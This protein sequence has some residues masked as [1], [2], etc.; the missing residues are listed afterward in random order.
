M[1]PE[2]DTLVTLTTGITLLTCVLAVVGLHSYAA[3]KA[4]RAPWSTASPRPARYR[5]PG[6]DAASRP[7]TAACAAPNSAG[8][9]NGACRPPAWT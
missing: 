2:L 3:G 1:E 8:T 7:W 9:W 4:Q 5:R 6:A